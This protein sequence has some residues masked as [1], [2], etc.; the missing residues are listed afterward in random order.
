[1]LKFGRLRLVDSPL[2]STT[3]TPSAVVQAVLRLRTSHHR[4]EVENPWESQ[5]Y[6]S[7][8]SSKL[9]IVAII[10]C[11]QP[12]ERD[13][14]E[15][16]SYQA[17]PFD[18]PGLCSEIMAAIRLHAPHAIVAR[19]NDRYVYFKS[20]YCERDHHHGVGSSHS[21][22]CHLENYSG[23]PQY[24]ILY[25][26]ELEAS[27]QYSYKIDKVSAKFG[28]DGIELVRSQELRVKG[29]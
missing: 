20:P 23:S 2:L 13:F 3:P 6:N 28:A 7:K 17:E 8:S 25:P 15:L 22:H 10:P 26:Y 4:L 11:F 12:D 5:D 16:E 24:S 1:M 19:W 27:G 14:H 9:I 21:A 29:K 18:Q